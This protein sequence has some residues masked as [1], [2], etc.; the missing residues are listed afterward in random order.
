MM[1]DMYGSRPTLKI[2]RLET[3]KSCFGSILTIFSVLLMFSCFML[4][5]MQLFNTSNPKIV[6]SVRNIFNAP[7]YQLSTANYGFTLGLQNPFTY[8]QFIDESI[9]RVDVYL[10][11]AKRISVNKYSEF[12]WEVTPL[13]VVLCHISKFPKSF[14][15]IFVNNPLRDMYCLKNNSFFLAGTFINHQ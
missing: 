5:F 4:F 6:H 10:K 14:Y 9:Y 8:N 15:S 3:F 1:A 11:H 13:E 12:Q 2:G 7:R